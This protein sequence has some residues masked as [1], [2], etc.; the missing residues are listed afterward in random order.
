[1]S[2]SGIRLGSLL[3]VAGADL[4]PTLREHIGQSPTRAGLV[5]T[6]FGLGA[7]AAAGKLRETLDVDVVELLAGAWLKF[8]A[9][10]E[11]RDAARH[12][13][14]EVSVVPLGEHDIVSAH[15]AVMQLEVAGIALPELRLHV[16][17]RAHFESVALSI[18]GGRIVAVAPGECSAIVRLKYGDTLLKQQSTPALQL[19]GRIDLGAGL[20]IP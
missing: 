7:D 6:V 4:E 17:L 5:A 10:R 9:L 1:M 20:A 8:A 15:D 3:A 2:A 14:G 13:P 19:P 16:E 11:Y 18:E 12:P